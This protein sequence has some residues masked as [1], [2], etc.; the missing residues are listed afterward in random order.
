MAVKVTLVGV[1]PTVFSTSCK[2]VCDPTGL[3]GVRTTAHQLSEYP[4]EVR[5]NTEVVLSAARSLLRYWPDVVVEVVNAMSLKG[6][7]LSAIHRGARGVFAVLKGKRYSL[8]SELQQLLE[9][10][11]RAISHLTYNS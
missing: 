2:A 7:A 3:A 9:D 5:R 1:L 11:E 10:V 6:L 8:P 4:E